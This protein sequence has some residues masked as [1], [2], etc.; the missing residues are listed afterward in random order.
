M[1]YDFINEHKKQTIWAIIFGIIALI[2][3]S[4]VTF[5]STHGY[6]TISSVDASTI[7][8]NSD[9]S[10]QTH[11]A[12]KSFSG[13]L[14]TGTYTA[15]VTKGNQ[16]TAQYIHVS[17][18]SSQSLKLALGPVAND[19]EG[20]TNFPLSSLANNG[21]DLSFIDNS[22]SKLMTTSDT[23]LL[24]PLYDSKQFTTINWKNGDRS[25]GI[26]PQNNT[27]LYFNHT[28]ATAIS[29]PKESTDQMSL[30]GALTGKNTLYITENNTL[31]S[32]QYPSKNY[33]TIT[34]I[35]S[36]AIIIGASDRGVLLQKYTAGDGDDFSYTYL[37]VSNDGHKYTHTEQGVPSPSTPLSA[38]LSPDGT[39]II[40]VNNSE[41][42]IY[43]SSF[44]PQIQ[45]PLTTVSAAAWLSDSSI[46]FANNESIWK[47]NT[48]KGQA[49]LLSVLPTAKKYIGIKQ[50][51]PS[52]VISSIYVN[53]ATKAIYFQLTSTDSQ[54]TYSIPQAT[55]TISKSAEGLALTA[56]SVFPNNCT[57]YFINTHGTL[58]YYVHTPLLSSDVKGSNDDCHTAIYQYLDAIGIP[59]SDVRFVPY[60]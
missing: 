39:H 60:S 11:T 57:A 56:P 58:A 35:P 55:A 32:T 50:P 3:I 19:A 2:I 45:L 23:T 59:S 5:L 14:A 13:F 12:T 8:I 47:Y 54:T 9:N 40:V 18:F 4:I 46:I 49:Q 10:A 48:T 51:A 42:T 41:A 1:L 31:Y 25:K 52:G 53:Q 28:S 30:S 22:T 44:S 24:K 16:K 27:L 43:S 38:R 33:H 36:G 34:T 15:I 37:F 26:A 6:V 7:T 21:S 20:V 17:P 29:L